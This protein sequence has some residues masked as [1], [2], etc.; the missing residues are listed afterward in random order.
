M[1]TNLKR[2]LAAAALFAA[3]RPSPAAPA[4]LAG[5]DVVFEERD[6][7]VAVEAEHFH[8]QTLADTRAWHVIAPGAAPALPGADKAAALADAG[9]G[10]FLHCL[11]DT[12]RTHDD[13]LVHG[14]NFSSEPGRLAVL[15]YRVHF[16][17]PGRYYVWVR[18]FS[19]GTEDN[20][21]H[22]GMNG[23]W[24]ASGRRLQW[25]EG[26][27]AW[28]WES[29]QRTEQEHCG[30]PHAI[31]LDVPTAGEHEV[32]FS[33]REDGFAFDKFILTLDREFARPEDA[34]PPPRLRSGTLPAAF[35]AAAAPPAG[36]TNGVRT[37]KAFPAHWGKPPD[38]Q[39]MD[40]RPLPGGYGHGS[41][42]LAGWIQRHLDR[43]QVADPATRYEQRE[44]SFDG[45]GRFY[46]GRELARYMSFHGAPWLERLEREE[47]ERPSKLIEALELRP[48]MVVA[49]IGAGTGYHAWRM[50]R[51]VAPGGRVY[52][53]DI[54][55]EML[56]LLAAN[57]AARGVT[58]VTGVLGTVTD[59]KLPEAALD[60]ALYVDV[61]HECD[62][63]WEMLAA[64]L[65]ALKPG[66]RLVLVEFRAEDRLVPIKPL[67]KMSEAQVRRELA[68]FPELEFVA[69]LPGSPWQ[70]ILV[71]RKR[72]G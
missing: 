30:V 7:R 67:H 46:L 55:P 34:G 10:A 27:H 6:G 28:R 66:G 21:L 20:G 41:S 33:M 64:T 3:F 49:D 58:N 13:P 68:V 32:Q 29:R 42:T 52:A 69:N 12:R 72:A 36:D 25:C 57:V 4:P 16:H 19:T 31:Y 18:A 54:Q 9:G 70:H 26:K 23:E 71:F 65:R 2:L 62:H 24:P 22:V 50:A 14:E 43:D 44:A 45:T 37:R 47:E 60:L 48:G 17:T 35:G 15:H 1:Q 8:R 56:D 5:P 63:P 51:L 61:Y 40:Y 38:I 59:P 53:V 11:P 39:T